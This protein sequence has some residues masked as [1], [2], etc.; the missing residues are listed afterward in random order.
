MG[1]STKQT[2]PIYRPSYRYM[3]DRLK[4]AREAA[5][6]TQREVAAALGY[7]QNRITACET[8][9]RRIDPI[10]LREFA[11][12]YEK[13]MRYFEPPEGMVFEDNPALYRFL[14]PTKAPTEKRS[15]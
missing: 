4:K 12:L 10:E 5:G 3:L 11:L 9:Q 8:G 15:E 13:S 1:R 14:Y 6:L 2:P 7:S